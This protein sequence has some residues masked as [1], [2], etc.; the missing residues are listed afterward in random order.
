[1]IKA[2]DI[3]EMP[4]NNDKDRLIGISVKGAQWLREKAYR[5][6]LEE[7]GQES[8][9]PQIEGVKLAVTNEDEPEVVQ[10]EQPKAPTAEEKPE[11][12]AKESEPQADAPE[13][14]KA[15]APEP[16][17]S[18][19]VPEN[20]IEQ[21]AEAEVQPEVVP[22]PEQ[23]EEAPEEPKLEVVKNEKETEEINPKEASGLNV[24]DYRPK[25][26]LRR[27]VIEPSKESEIKPQKTSHGPMLAELEELLKDSPQNKSILNTVERLKKVDA[28]EVAGD[29]E[30]IEKVLELLWDYKR[31]LVP[32]NGEPKE[33][34]QKSVDELRRNIEDVLKQDSVLEERTETV[35]HPLLEALA[36]VQDAL[37]NKGPL[38]Q[39][40]IDAVG[41]EIAR[42][43]IGLKGDITRD[44]GE[45]LEKDFISV[46]HDTQKLIDALDKIY[47]E[48]P[49]VYAALP[50]KGS[51]DAARIDEWEE[52]LNR[53][54]SN[55]P[56]E[57]VKEEEPK[58]P[59]E[60]KKD[61][62]VE[63]AQS[64]EVEKPQKALPP[65]P[66]QEALPP[67]VED[68]ATFEFWNK[69]EKLV[70]ADISDEVKIQAMVIRDDTFQSLRRGQA[71]E[72]TGFTGRVRSLWQSMMAGL[73][74]YGYSRQIYQESIDI[75]RNANSLSPQ[76]QARIRALG[77][78]DLS[79][80]DTGEETSFMLKDAIASEI[81]EGLLE[82]SELGLDVEAS[83]LELADIFVNHLRG[84]YE[85]RSAFERAVQAHLDRI[86]T[87]N[88]QLVNEVFGEDFEGLMYAGNLWEMA[89]ANRAKV[90]ESLGNWE[91]LTPE[92]QEQL[93]EA[94]GDLQGVRIQLAVKDRAI[95]EGRPAWVS[96]DS[97]YNQILDR[98]RGRNFGPVM[99]FL[100]SA[101]VLG[102]AGSAATSGV[103]RTAL[104]G[105]AIVATG[106]MGAAITPLL[107]GAATGSIVAAFRKNRRFDDDFATEQRRMS[108]GLV[109]EG[110]KSERLQR[111]GLGAQTQVGTE[112]ARQI[113]AGDENAAYEAKALL[114][115]ERELA[116]NGMPQDLIVAGDEEGL[117]TRS[118]VIS[119]RD[120]R[121]A[122]KAFE[123]SKE[124]NQEVVAERVRELLSF[125]EGQDTSRKRA[126]AASVAGAAAYGFVSGLLAGILGREAIDGV[127]ERIAGAENNTITLVEAALGQRAQE[128]RMPK[129]LT[130]DGERVWVGMQKVQEVTMKHSGK[131]VQ[132]TSILGT[133]GKWHHSAPNVEGQSGWTFDAVKNEI[134]HRV[135]GIRKNV[136][137]DWLEVRNSVAKN[138]GAEKVHASW[139][140]QATN[141]IKGTS[142][143]TELGMTFP[144]RNG[145]FSI[146]AESM[147]GM[148]AYGRGYRKV[149]N[150]LNGE[151]VATISAYDP[152]LQHEAIVLPLGKDLKTGA[153]DMLDQFID[154]KTHQPKPGILITV[155]ERIR[156]RAGETDLAAIAAIG[157]RGNTVIETPGFTEGMQFNMPDPTYFP[158]VEAKDYAEAWAV[159]FEGNAPLGETTPNKERNEVPAPAPVPPAAT[160]VEAA[161][162]GAAMEPSTATKRPVPPLNANV[163]EDMET[164]AIPLAPGE[165][166]GI[167]LEEQAP[168]VVL[169]EESKEE[170][171]EAEPVAVPAEEPEKPKKKPESTEP[172]AE[173]EKPKE[174]EKKPKED[175]IKIDFSGVDELQEGRKNNLRSILQTILNS[176][177]SLEVKLTELRRLVIENDELFGSAGKSLGRI[178]LGGTK[179]DISKLR[180]KKNFEIY[181]A[182][183][184]KHLGGSVEAE[185]EEAA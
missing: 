147:E 91:S 124:L 161:E 131:T 76:L 135:E 34:T 172:K 3:V 100:T 59:A 177:D 9:E 164:G 120:L 137:S 56:K 132:V 8:T 95:Q 92:V 45:P 129:Y 119:R 112:L 157:T 126:K 140:A 69:E 149:V 182:Q 151:Y 18:E 55:L 33:E 12:E 99:G 90:T 88:P 153:L 114:A 42:V 50:Q 156:D 183:V 2:G 152:K 173:A 174:A 163:A 19:I 44:S 52:E 39:Q 160:Q 185:Q 106:G 111:L 83:A 144:R 166:D 105:T 26:A 101:P 94:V 53:W 104:A 60:E 107:V 38:T 67:H 103:V 150:P 61:E 133:D 123:A 98:I 6:A 125:A 74:D 29:P 159:P 57:A 72:A 130:P 170:A 110:R 139:V 142:D 25:G 141:R 62:E 36:R 154:P 138:T 145:K 4:G 176:D 7:H 58:A 184:I 158:G 115:T 96:N 155:S 73:G 122:L 148:L 89:E 117:E 14:P 13:E 1:M 16:V 48:L 5:D 11:E 15:E 167:V 180:S 43:K 23:A 79:T 127:S 41:E 86:T 84:E 10:P 108:R 181:L 35:G 22:E 68:A 128:A 27:E 179:I 113:E 77:G 51:L 143:G 17:V 162:E 54:I 85:D 165:E 64:S 31:E 93:L 47:A 63:K 65:V 71:G 20:Q 75:M 136:V 46:D 66:K 30:D 82:A 169:P 171:K 37:G 28:G 146:N 70:L 118:S 24:D 87:Q 102:F 109:G 49:G 121:R 116:E 80:D 168:E 134:T 81:T 78:M 40:D 178:N 32:N 97:R 21:E 175:E